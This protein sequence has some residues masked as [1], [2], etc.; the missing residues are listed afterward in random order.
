MKLPAE[1]CTSDDTEVPQASKVKT[2]TRD[3]SVHVGIVPDNSQQSASNSSSVVEDVHKSTGLMKTDKCHKVVKKLKLQKQPKDSCV[4]IPVDAERL[5]N[6]AAFG[7]QCFGTK[8]SA[9]VTYVGSGVMSLSD[10]ILP[11]VSGTPMLS[12]ALYT[13]FIEDG[14][15]QSGS[16]STNVL[17]PQYTTSHFATASS[18]L[19]PAVSTASADLCSV[20]LSVVDTEVVETADEQSC[21]S[22]PLNSCTPLKKQKHS[23]SQG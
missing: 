3:S 21:S 2:V 22:C 6:I 4:A 23:S 12:Y 5:Q 16:Q 19:V 15:F 17:S 20:D 13:P 18:S 11:H 9:K 8:T 10:P 7:A 1:T 14:Q